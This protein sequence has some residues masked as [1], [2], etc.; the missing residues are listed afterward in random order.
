MARELDKIKEPDEGMQAKFWL[1][2]GK[3]INEPYIVYLRTERK[4]AI[5]Y[6]HKNI[7]FAKCKNNGGIEDGVCLEWG[8]HWLWSG[9]T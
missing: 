9:S 4:H 8:R 2:R 6:R 1:D 7:R 5:I 3:V